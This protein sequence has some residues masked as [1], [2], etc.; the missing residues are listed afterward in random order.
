MSCFLDCESGSVPGSPA[1]GS[2]SDKARGARA[3]RWER[4]LVQMPPGPDGREE[5][6]SQIP[7]APLQL[8]SLF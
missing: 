5:T 1:S 2:H 4:L 7:S 6:K 3:G 8:D